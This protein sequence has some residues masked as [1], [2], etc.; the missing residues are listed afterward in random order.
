[1]TATRPL[2]NPQRLRLLLVL[3][4]LLASVYTI[5]YSG[6]IES[7]DSR[8]LFDAVSSLVDYGDQ[9]ID[10]AAW[11]FPP[12]PHATANVRSS[13]QLPLETANIEPMQ[14]LASAPL[15]WLA[16]HIPNIG[17]VHT[18]YLFNIIIGATVGSAL[19]LYALALGYEERTAALATIAFG[20]GTAVFPY[21]KSFFREPLMMLCLLLT[22]LA[23]E[24]LRT[25]GYRSWFWFVLGVLALLALTLT[26]A[27]GLLALPAL[28]VL[29][30]P[31]LRHID[32][33]LIVA[34]GIAALVLVGLFVALGVLD[35][36]PSLSARYDVLR[37]LSEASSTYLGVALHSYLFSVG[38]S[39]WGTS[40]VVLLA[41]P[42]AWMLLRRGQFRYPL[43]ILLLVLAFAFGYALLNTVHWFGGLSWPPRFLIPVLPF[44]VIGALP[45]L[46]WLAHH[47]R[48]LWVIPALL[49]FAYS[50]W[51]Q[52]SGVAL[53]WGVYATVLPTEAG[54]LLEWGGG[55]NQI[56][57]LRW[58]VIPRLWQ[59]QP[60]DNAWALTNTAFVPWL[61]AGMALVCALWV[62]RVGLGTGS[63]DGRRR[64]L[65]VYLPAGLALAYLLIVW[66]GLRLLYERDG[67]TFAS[68]QPL[69]EMLN[70]IDARTTRDD[71][72][73]L[74]SPRYE[75]FF[76]N[77]YKPFDSARAIVL[78][79]Q[80]GE[81]PSPEQQPLV[82]SDYPLA[83]LTAETAP[84]IHSLGD[85]HE[86]LWLLVQ[87]GPDY[88]WSTRPVERFMSGH[89]YPVDYQQTAPDVRLV[90]YGT[91]S[92][93]DVF[94]FH[95]AERAADLSFGA[96][97]HLTGFTLSA[98]TDYAP[99][100]ILPVSLYW[101][102]D[103]P[104]EARYTVAVYLSQPGG[105]PATQSDWQPAGN[106][107]PTNTW[108]VS[109]PVWDHRGLQLPAGL[110]PGVYQLWVKVYDNPGGSPPQDLPVTGAE[111][112]DGVIG[113]L[114][115]EINVSSE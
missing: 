83:L 98:G 47:P 88:P 72:L 48:S 11:Q 6:A 20:L 99:G 86:R 74:G 62:W 36:V 94:A 40:P 101:Q 66:A 109:A 51:V 41:L 97:I 15:Y 46:D 45:A 37:R 59:H 30:V 114:P 103:A 1:M 69:H 110:A 50:L 9:Y 108:Q 19:F 34:L 4:V 38:G 27:S 92:A 115:V 100:E 31:S 91:V 5:S 32:R 112:I 80:P 64:W 113:V 96:S 44:L 12:Q 61:F 35:L 67:R 111:T 52:I 75:P 23:V 73:L 26:K 14:V 39:I 17:L 33:R 71:V 77:Y 55:L 53:H 63:V 81:Q 84:L 42:G 3:W 24:R 68:E 78:P 56:E 43:A 16:K 105:L 22:G 104:L 65:S 28:L 2:L 93:P 89:Y 106:F 85:M 7:G 107:A 8:R 58:V 54:S 21:S 76:L 10:L 25:S 82:R 49:L 29:A 90:E 70:V 13:G 87:F 60:L 95:G 57:Y 18:T 79:L 102:T